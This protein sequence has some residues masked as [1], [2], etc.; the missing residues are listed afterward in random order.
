M[1]ATNNI[2][3]SKVIELRCLRDEDIGMSKAPILMSYLPTVYND[4]KF[5]GTKTTV[6]RKYYINKENNTL[7]IPVDCMLLIAV[8][9]EDECGSIKGM[10]YN[11]AL[12]KE[13]LFEN[14]IDCGCST[15]GDA[16]HLCSNVA[17]FDKTEDTVYILGEPYT[18]T[19]KTTIL[20]DGRIIK[21]THTP[22][23]TNGSGDEE[24]VIYVD[25]EEVVCTM[26]LLP[27]GCIAPTPTNQ[28]RIAELHQTCCSLSTN[29]GTY[30]T[31]CCTNKDAHTYT[32]DIQGKLIVLSPYYLRDYII[33]KYVTVV[34]QAGDYEIPSIALECVLAGLKYYYE[35]GNPKAQPF[36]RGQN[37][38]FHRM[39][40]A[41]MN[42]LR[43]RLRPIPYQKYMNAMGVV[44][45]NNPYTYNAYGYNGLGYPYGGNWYNG[46]YFPNQLNS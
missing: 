35:S 2:P 31:D 9:Y 1:I 45:Y 38:M 46:V 30:R 43:R 6:M 5:D 13:I 42:K 12:P 22:M 14:Q 44:P 37:G 27:C 36:T 39:Y 28:E 10:W 34:N 11:D 19:T 32:L 17:S 20:N 21:N 29:N 15:C 33:L 8:G 26:D 4:L 3:A 16:G 24:E 40:T 23:L 25:N 18:K 41:E 7:P